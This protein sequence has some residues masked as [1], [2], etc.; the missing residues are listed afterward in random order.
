MFPGVHLSLS[1]VTTVVD[2]QR[3]WETQSCVKCHPFLAPFQGGTPN[4][5]TVP[6]V[7]AS[8]SQTA[9]LSVTNMAPNWQAQSVIN[10]RVS[11]YLP[12]V[13]ILS[14]K[15]EKFQSCSMHCY[16]ILQMDAKCL[17]GENNQ[18]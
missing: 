15:A 13:N 4:L 10:T 5:Q 6:A 9:A 3:F 18:F 12:V 8:R 11:D 7:P 1:T 16:T 14:G 2:H 17:Y